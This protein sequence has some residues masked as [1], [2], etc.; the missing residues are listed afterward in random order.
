VIPRVTV[1]SRN[2]WSLICASSLARERASRRMTPRLHQSE[3]A[4]TAPTMCLGR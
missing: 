3:E 1:L 2:A 4:L